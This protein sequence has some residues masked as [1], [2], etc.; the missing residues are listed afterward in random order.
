MARLRAALND[1]PRAPL[2]RLAAILFVLPLLVHCRN[3]PLEEASTSAPSESEPVVDD[4]ASTKVAAN[5]VGAEA[6]TSVVAVAESSNVD[7][8]QA[9]VC[10]R[11][12]LVSVLVW[13]GSEHVDAGTSCQ[14]CHGTSAGHVANERNE[15]K[16]DQLPRGEAIA[17]LCSDCHEDG[18]P[19]TSKV[20]DCQSCH[21]VHA[22]VDPSA[23][24]L[25]TKN[26]RLATLFA[27][28]EDFRAKMTAGD[29][30]TRQGEWRAARAEFQAALDLIPSNREARSRIEYCKR[31]IEPSIAGFEVAAQSKVDSSTGLP[32]QVTVQGLDIE[33][34]LIPPGD[35]DMGAD[36][37]EDS[38][39]VHTVRCDAFYLGKFEVT[40]A[41][42]VSVMGNN[43][44]AHTAENSERLP[45]E[46]VS[47]KQCQEFVAKLNERVPGGGFR[48]P[49]EAECCLL[50]TS[51]AAADSFV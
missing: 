46:R 4:N 40:Q 24:D 36:E 25:T 30:L 50:Y 45:V 5:E 49:T 7:M 18:C 51:D 27:L 41:Q 43:P 6:S 3:A 8:P 13:D 38:Q 22:L 42:W 17:G 39:P 20:A 15:V 28:W 37:M 1:R 19:E 31:R 2:K 12:Q 10:S 23:T 33:M 48:L 35:F 14:E 26:E 29:E 21:H 16:P 11:C 44:S 34:V 9:G 47:W 32:Q